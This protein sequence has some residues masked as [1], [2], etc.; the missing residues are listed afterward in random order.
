[1]EKNLTQKRIADKNVSI[2]LL[3]EFSI[4]LTCCSCHHEADFLFAEI[5]CPIC[6]GLLFS[7]AELRAINWRKLMK[8]FKQ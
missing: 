8:E 2:K 7:E 4:H 1:M 5:R 3:P 6:D